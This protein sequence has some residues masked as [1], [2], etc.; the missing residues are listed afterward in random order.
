MREKE[1]KLVVGKRSSLL[2]QS[3]DMYLLV[4]YDPYSRLM[5]VTIFAA[6][7]YQIESATEGSM[8]VIL[9]QTF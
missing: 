9:L 5:V 6:R 4:T 7:S 8:E 1:F 2:L 3:K